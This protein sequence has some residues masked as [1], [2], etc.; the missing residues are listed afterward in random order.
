MVEG[1]PELRLDLVALLIQKA[2]RPP[3]DP[4]LWKEAE[5]QLGTAEKALPGAV[6]RLTF[7]KVDLLAAQDRLDEARALLAAAQAKDSRNLRYRLALARLT[8]R[9]GK[10]AAALQ[11]V[12]QAEKDMG[13]SLDIQL[14]RL[15]YWGLKGGEAAK[16][17]VAKLAESRE[18]IPAAHRPA[19]LDRLAMTEIR[20]REPALARQY[21][22]ELAAL[23][24]DNL[25]VRLVLFDL[26]IEAGDRGA[27]ADLVS[28][29]RK[30]EG[31]KGTYWRFAQATLRDPDKV[32]RGVSRDL[33]EARVLA[34]EIS[35][36]QPDWWGGPSLKASSP[37]STGSPVPLTRQ[38]NTTF[39][40]SSWGMFNL[41]SLADS[42][43]CST[44]ET[45]SRTL[46]ALPR[47]SASMASR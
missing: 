13:P 46:T 26:A 47:S 3:P 32:R 20:L 17:A 45:V 33:E 40:R 34:A 9:Q 8:Q 21:Y 5:R 14:A 23:E 27:A 15:D 29:V 19:F 18:Q 31:D 7:L 44:S 12:D 36:R 25:R 43:D 35:E 24:P 10:G 37:S 2:S 41:R 1:K 4:R 22:G 30:I 16:A 6:E 38:L 11:I 42:W 39:T 28:Q